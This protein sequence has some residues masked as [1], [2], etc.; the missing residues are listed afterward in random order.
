M[1]FRSLI[2]APQ[3]LLQEGEKILEQKDL[4]SKFAFR[5]RIV[6]ILLRGNMTA[7][8]LAESTGLSLSCVRGWLKSVDIEGWEAL[9]EKTHSGRRRKLTQE[10]EEQL[11]K[12]ILSDPADYGYKEWSGTNLV[13][14][15]EKTFGVRLSIASVLN[16]KNDITRNQL[17]AK[18]SEPA[19][20]EEPEAPEEA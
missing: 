11:E 5:V 9:K 6:T 19:G 13:D 4:D 12:A 18:Y 10:Q 7:K 2:H 20:Q 8:E 15:L 14:Y 3:D 16:R 17:K 1:R